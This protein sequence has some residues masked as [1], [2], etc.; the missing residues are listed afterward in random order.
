MLT[1]VLH[2]IM[3]MQSVA[4][5]PLT[6]PDEEMKGTD[7]WELTADPSQVG[8]QPQDPRLE[9]LGCLESDRAL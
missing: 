7:E 2:H 1:Q 5:T 3:Q 4:A 9:Q 8:N 6:G